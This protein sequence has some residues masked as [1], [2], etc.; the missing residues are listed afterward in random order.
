[1][2]LTRRRLAQ[3]AAFGAN[4]AFLGKNQVSG[5]QQ[6]SQS[7]NQDGLT[8]RAAEFIVQTKYADLPRELLELGKKSILDGIGLALVGSAGA[9]GHLTRTYLKSLGIS[10]D[11]A[12]ILGSSMKS[13]PR[14][15]AFANGIGI[16]A[17]D[18]DDTQLAVSPD[19]VY[20]LLT[21]PTAPC[22]SAAW[23]VA[24]ARGMSGRELMLAY[25]LG[26][27]VECK[28]A[29]AI[30]PRHYED[31][32]H[33]TG[34]CGTFAA[35]AAAVKLLGADAPTCARALGIAGSESAGLRENFGTMTKPF[36]AGR[37]A[38][39]GV[40]AADLAMLG[41][42]ASDMILEAPNGFFH[43]AGGSGYNAA[44]MNLAQP[45][46]FLSPGISIKPF[47]SGSLTHPAMT[48]LL[49]LIH[50]NNITAQ[51]IERLDVGANR[52]MPSALIHH[53]PTNALQ[54]KFSMEFC[55]AAILLYGRAGLREFT[56]EVVRRPEV[57]AMIE[58][59]H[60]GVHPEAEKAGYNKMTSI[61]D[62]R[63]LD[64]RT[65]SGRA[66]FAKGSPADPMTY[67]EAAAKFE[68]CA[69]FATWPNDKM[70]AIVES[71]RTLEE[72]KDVRSLA[73]L[74]SG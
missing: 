69:R 70:A 35:A 59:V 67:D 22:L 7:A 34:T 43:A 58:R 47:P 17:D 37:A 30:A 25:H 19:R 3:L 62:I 33:S 38:E 40:V 49:R 14:F 60:F 12:T 61:V 48:A 46:T 56:D 39:S 8:R 29:E 44:A 27:E 55:M 32:F 31:G 1:M 18:Y 74:C 36:H 57:K 68:D 20:G 24:E 42:T 9:L 10:R 13:S 73:K 52:N 53:R 54:A 4:A 72:I 64:G 21:H 28:I 45:W 15:A 66:D 71:V 26:V 23:A 6:N 5:L 50:A 16:H 11:E 41:W 51:Q 2:R 63:L 65:I